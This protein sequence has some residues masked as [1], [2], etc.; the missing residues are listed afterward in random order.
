[1]LLSTLL[2]VLF[3][4]SAA[5]PATTPT[6]DYRWPLQPLP[7]VVRGYEAPPQP[8]AAGHRGADLLG[9]AAQAVLAAGDGVISYQGVLAGRGVVSVQHPNGWKTTYEPVVGAL[10]VGTAVNR[11]EQIGVLAATQS[12]CAPSIC[13][14][15]GLIIAPDS[16][17]D[18]LT[19]L[20]LRAPVLLPLTD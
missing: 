15:W 3:G 6:S 20:T 16:Y 19:L 11:G 4:L 5:S 2:F 13:L 17:R 8:W 10:P 14:H 9:R 1:M 7:T 18:P 12:H